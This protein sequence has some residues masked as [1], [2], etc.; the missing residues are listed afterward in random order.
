MGVQ[1]DE[2]G[3][4]SIE[5]RGE[6]LLIKIDRPKKLNGFTPK[7]FEELGAA[8]TSLESRKFRCGVLYANGDSFT[9]GLDLPKVSPLMKA[10]QELVPEKYID[11]FGLRS[12]MRTTPLVVAVK[13]YC[14]TLGIELML[15]ADIVIAAN[16]TRFSQLEVKR[17]VMATGGATIR[18]VER[19][20]WGNAMYVLLTGDEF[21]AETALR[22]NF[23]Q[24]VVET[25]TELARALEIA[26]NIANQAP[27]AVRETMRSARTALGQNRADAVREFRSVQSLLLNS[28]DAG[29]GLSSFVERRP[30][31]FVGK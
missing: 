15:A 25:G 1:R 6:L 22:M 17:G 13:G 11:P 23:V 9:A 5:A 12:P 2:N 19:A 4:V 21:S 28:V 30:A 10:G 16:D 7:M 29:E 3:T 14:Y 18:M 26:D 20:G 27:L 24:E 31:K 8:Y